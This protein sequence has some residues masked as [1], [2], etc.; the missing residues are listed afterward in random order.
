MDHFLSYVINDSNNALVPARHIEYN[1][2][3]LTSHNKLYIKKSPLQIIR[4]SCLRDFAT[5]EGKRKAVIHMTGFCKKVPIPINPA[6]RIF[7]FPTISPQHPECIWLFYYRIRKIE[8]NKGK[9]FKEYPSIVYFKDGTSLPL[10]ISFYQLDKQYKRTKRCI[11]IYEKELERNFASS[12]L[13]SQKKKDEE[14]E[15][16]AKK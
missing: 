10:G 6:K 4:E 2:I 5:Y 9:S 11:E 3:V 15:G 1:T 12:F 13:T 8:E 7:A 14:E 16:N